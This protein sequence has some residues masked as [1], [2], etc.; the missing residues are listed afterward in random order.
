MQIGQDAKEFG[1]QTS[2]YVKVRC[3]ESGLQ[4]LDKGRQMEER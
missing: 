2:N 4:T 3:L 1:I